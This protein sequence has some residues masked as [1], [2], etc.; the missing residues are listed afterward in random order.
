MYYTNKCTLVNYAL[1][2]NIQ[3][4]YSVIRIYFSSTGCVSTT[5]N[6]NTPDL[7]DFNNLNI[8]CFQHY[9]IRHF[10]TVETFNITLSSFTY[11]IWQFGLF[12]HHSCDDVL[13]MVPIVTENQ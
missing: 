8:I 11:T 13:M 3:A 4:I 12:Y 1:L 7:I 10:T 2:Y 9:I 5:Y 6:I